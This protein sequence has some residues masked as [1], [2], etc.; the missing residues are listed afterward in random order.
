MA[1]VTVISNTVFEILTLP[2][3][4]RGRAEAVG[5]TYVS[6]GDSLQ[7]ADIGLKSIETIVFTPTNSGQYSVAGSIVNV[8]AYDNSVT[9]SVYRYAST[10]ATGSFIAYYRATGIIS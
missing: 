4:R 10:A 6:N 3:K 2:G 8:G 7:S 5:K 9:L 1:N